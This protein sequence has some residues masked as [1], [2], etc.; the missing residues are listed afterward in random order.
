MVDVMSTQA[1]GWAPANP[2][3]AS[4]FAHRETILI[5]KE[6]IKILPLP[7]FLATKFTAFKSRGGKDPRTSHD[8]EDITYLLDNRTDLVSVVSKASADVV[9]F[10]KRAFD[11]M[12]NNDAGSYTEQS[13]L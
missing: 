6:T 13:V 2:W 12:I 10:L 5:A 7:Y 9:M 3:F 8:L 4:G 11:E 1:V